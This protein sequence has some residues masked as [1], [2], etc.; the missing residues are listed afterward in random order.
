MK[1]LKSIIP[2]I[3]K[4]MRPPKLASGIPRLVGSFNSVDSSE[5]ER[6]NRKNEVE[7]ALENLRLF[8]E[9]SQK[10]L[11][12]TYGALVTSILACVIS[13]FALVVAIIVI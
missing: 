7:V 6:A 11:N 4:T 10:N 2:R 12:L 1:S 9:V 13:V 3:A 8:R 5:E